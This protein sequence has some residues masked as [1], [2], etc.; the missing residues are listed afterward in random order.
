MNSETKLKICAITLICVMLIGV[1]YILGFSMYFQFNMY[2]W[3][4][5]QMH[6]NQCEYLL[7]D[8]EYDIMTRKINTEAELQKEMV[9]YNECK[10]SLINSWY[11][12]YVE[13][14]VKR[15]TPTL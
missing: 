15:R 1:V 2:A 6:L 7:N 12:K 8:V 3:R 14:Q 9:K 13:W 5:G 11:D 10:E 4:K